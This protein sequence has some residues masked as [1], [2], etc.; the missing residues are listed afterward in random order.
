MTKN[1]SFYRASPF[2]MSLI[3][4]ITEL[5]SPSYACKNPY[6]PLKHFTD[7]EPPLPFWEQIACVC[8]PKG[9]VTRM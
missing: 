7:K 3:T 6:I 5:S 4:E 1:Q 8:L 9:L 2:Y